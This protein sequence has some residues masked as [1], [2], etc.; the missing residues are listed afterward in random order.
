MTLRD[1]FKDYTK[2]DRFKPSTLKNHT[3]VV[4]FYLKDWL[5]KPVASITKEMVEKLFFQIRDHGVMGENRP[6]PRQSKP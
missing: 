3:Q 2:G 1:L 4:Q 6:T 5:D